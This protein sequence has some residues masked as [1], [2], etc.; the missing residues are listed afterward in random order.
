MSLGVQT[1]F[2]E[3]LRRTAKYVLL[4]YA[5]SIVAIIF[6]IVFIVIVAFGFLA[7]GDI[8]VAADTEEDLGYTLST[9]SIGAIVLVVVLGLVLYAVFIVAAYLLY[10]AF[11][12]LRSALP[13]APE[14]VRARLETP[15]TVLYY[16][17]LLMLVG[18]VTVIIVIGLLLILLAS[19]GLTVGNLLFGL[20]LRDIGAGL[21]TPGNLLLAGTILQILS[22]L[23]YIGGVFGM[24]G[25]IL[26]IVAYYMIYTWRG[27]LPGAA[28]TSGETGTIGGAPSF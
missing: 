13:S 27:S 14:I 1:G 25:F 18:V 12:G 5:V 28:E 16:S 4:S 9:L 2:E 26:E 15:V 22:V 23:P 24:I 6:F 11:S 10:K 19:L 8:A 20:S 21:E 7:V 3:A 17:A